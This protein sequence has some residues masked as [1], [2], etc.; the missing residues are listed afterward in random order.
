M[1]LEDVH[2][3]NDEAIY[4]IRVAFKRTGGHFRLVSEKVAK[5]AKE[6]SGLD[7]N[8]Y[9]PDLKKIIC[10]TSTRCKTGCKTC[11][12]TFCIECLDGYFYNA[13]SKTC[14]TTCF[15]GY[16][17]DFTNNACTKCNDACA[18]CIAANNCQT[19]NQNYILEI[20][21]CIRCSVSPTKTKCTSCSST[22][23][24]CDTCIAAY[25][26]DINKKCIV[27]STSAGCKICTFCIECLDGYITDSKTYI[28]CLDH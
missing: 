1:I 2:K 6:P 13:D 4:G 20:N 24:Q 11:D 8:V 28:K 21:S 5:I 3:G 14:N 23:C 12:G 7:E 27:C 15:Q 19:C 22:A 17:K 16:F 18:T 25:F 9:S 26:V 10:S